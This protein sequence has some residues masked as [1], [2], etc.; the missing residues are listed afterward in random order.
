[1]I[2]GGRYVNGTAWASEVFVSVSWKWSSLPFALLLLSLIFLF[3]VIFKSTAGEQDIG[4]LEDLRSP[5]AMNGLRGDV[6]W[7]MGNS[8][9]L[10]DIRSQSRMVDMELQ[11]GKKA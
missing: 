7:R 8:V 3:T 6:R 5:S 11:F 1:M 2:Q 9:G 4:I 10:G